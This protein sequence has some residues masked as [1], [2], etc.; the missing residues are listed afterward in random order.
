MKEMEIGGNNVPDDGGTRIQV[1]MS[2]MWC[3]T[4]VP[5]S[6]HDARTVPALFTEIRTGSG[7]LSGLDL[8]QLRIHVHLGHDRLLCTALWGGNLERATHD[9]AADLLHRDA[10]FSFS[11]RAS[12]VDRNGLLL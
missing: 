11:V 10:D 6:H 3:G 5:E 8:Y 7:I 4:T 12:L 1:A 9:S 2:T